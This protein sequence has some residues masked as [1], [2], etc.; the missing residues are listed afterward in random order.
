MTK[1]VIVSTNCSVLLI[2]GQFIDKHQIETNI[3]ESINMIFIFTIF[4][5]FQQIKSEAHR[6]D[7]VFDVTITQVLISKKPSQKTDGYYTK[8]QN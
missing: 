5:L 7:A 1:N 4:C 8:I 3:Y 6:F 2:G